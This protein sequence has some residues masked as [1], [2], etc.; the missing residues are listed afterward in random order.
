MTPGLRRRVPART[1]LLAAWSLLSAVMLALLSTS[2][3]GSRGTVVLDDYGS[4]LAPAA[5]AVGCFLACRRETGKSARA[6]FLLGLSLLSWAF[7]G[8]IWTSYEVYLGRDIPFPS[9]ADVGYL[10]SVPLAVAALLCFPGSQFV[11]MARMRPVLDGAIA[12]GALLFVSWTTVLGPAVRAGSGSLLTQ[13]LSLA[14]PACDVVTASIALLALA[15]ARDGQRTTMLLV[16]VGLVL[17]AA[18]DSAFAWFTAHGNYSSENSFDT[19]YIAGFLLIGV[20]A[21]QHRPL[22][23]RAV[24]EVSDLV[25]PLRFGMAIPYIPLLIGVPLAVALQ[26]DGKPLDTFQLSITGFVIVAV[27]LRQVL[28]LQLIVGLSTQLHSTVAAMRNQEAELQTTVA[29][30]RDREVELHHQAFHDPLT[31]LANRTLF[32]DRVGHA[33]SR[34]RRLGPVILLLADL[35]D[36]KVVNDT[37]GHP[38]GDM[39]LITVADRLRAV[40]RPEDTVARL[41]GDEFA[42]LLDAA[43]GLDDARGVADRI[44]QAMLH[45]FYLAGVHTVM[46][47]SIGI[48]AADASASA[49]ALLRDA[50]I[51]MYAAKAQGKGRCAVYAAEFAAENLGRLQLKSDLSQALERGELSLKYQPIVDL[52]TGMMVGVEALLRWM[53]PTLGSVPR[54]AYI[55]IAETSGAMLP[56][57]R[58]VLS[59]ACAQAGRWQRARPRGSA[60]IGLSVNLAGR[61]LTDPLLLPAVEG[62]LVDAGLAPSCLTLEITESILLDDE[63]ILAPLMELKKLGVHVAIDDFGTGH[64]ALTRLRHYPI[65]TLKV[66]QSF[67]NA[68]TPEAPVPDVLITTILSLGRGLGMTVIAEGV[69]TEN[70]L[71]AL[72]VLGCRQAQGFLFARPAEPDVIGELIH[73]GIALTDPVV[74]PADGHATPGSRAD[75]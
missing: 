25:A 75:A 68:L 53:H 62:A 45:P 26:L 57:G 29:S 28:S 4:M 13:G 49:E 6:W 38:A 20:A 36:F 42:V 21:L 66:D 61:Q 60:A 33:L 16:S 70:Q 3:L 63:V 41:G 48:A 23:K 71:A 43:E 47:A 24:A 14:Y 40:V 44:T 30:L 39:L 50:D 52:D 17:V 31:G 58:W 67:V 69:E 5:A 8:L 46:G 34:S 64:S 35:D 1:P 55:P 10:G 56:I 54:S 32:A 74:A 22:A 2:A 9:L 19:G 72:R 65:D 7:G 12:A 15:R 11:G 73:A 59:Q 51:A 18:A 27:L 37:L